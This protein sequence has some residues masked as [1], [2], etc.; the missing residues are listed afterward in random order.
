MTE[1]INKEVATVEKTTTALATN[2][3]F[4]DGLEALGQGDLIIPRLTIG[5]PQTDGILEEH[6]GMLLV[7]VTGEA[8][9][10]L[11]LVAIK[12]SKSRIM[13]PAKYKKDN[14]PLCRSHDFI[15]PADDIEGAEA[16]SEKCETCKYS[17]WSKN[18]APPCN[19]VWNFLVI[20]TESYM[21]M[22]FSVKS[23]GIKGAKRLV[24]ALKLMSQAK[25]LPLWGFGFVLS[26]QLQDDGNPYY[27]PVFSKPAALDSDELESMNMIRDQMQNADVKDSSEP[28]ENAEPP[29][30]D[31][32]DE[33]F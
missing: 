22:W 10:E 12:L 2:E 32:E 11:K 3:P 24:S 20:D 6:K 7:N 31:K 25:R 13:F 17:K 5:Q 14:D 29:F 8:A 1:E 23:T 4:D 30:E 16:M 15:V 26:T 9:S 28:V 18:E 21:P 19:E 27:I 33:P